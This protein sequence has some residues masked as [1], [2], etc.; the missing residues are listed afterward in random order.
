MELTKK[1]D[2]ELFIRFPKIIEE[3][4]SLDYLTLWKGFFFA[5]FD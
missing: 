4:F 5:F 3:L 1:K 2:K